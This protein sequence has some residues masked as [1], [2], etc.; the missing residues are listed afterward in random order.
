MPPP[1]AAGAE[2]CLT[3]RQHPPRPLLPGNAV[4]SS[5]PLPR[6]DQ[7]LVVYC[8]SHWVA[9]IRWPVS[10][11]ARPMQSRSLFWCCTSTLPPPYPSPPFLHTVC[12]FPYSPTPPALRPS[13]F[14]YREPSCRSLPS[15]HRCHQLLLGPLRPFP[16][17]SGQRHIAHTL[18]K[19][20][21]NSPLASSR[22][23]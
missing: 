15:H 11:R 23:G 16:P 19:R 2:C 18:Q 21:S 22:G 12:F 4:R 7:G 14:A 6:V 8:T 5:P 17:M 20:V 10:I 1:L 3:A 13:H 9:A